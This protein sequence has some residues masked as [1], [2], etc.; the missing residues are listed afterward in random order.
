MPGSSAAIFPREINIMTTSVE[1]HALLSQHGI[2]RVKNDNREEAE[3][4]KNFIPIWSPILS[5]RKNN[6]RFVSFKQYRK[7]DKKW[8]KKKTEKTIAG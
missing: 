3:K 4:Q 7:G 6:S 5:E 8:P 1:M 2:G